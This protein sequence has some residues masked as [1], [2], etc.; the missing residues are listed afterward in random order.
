MAQ[1]KVSWICSTQSKVWQKLSDVGVNQTSANLKLSGLRHQTWH[2]FGGCFNEIGWDVLQSLPVS[3]R[4][5]ILASLFDSSKGCCLNFGR[6]PMGAS[7]Y[8]LQWYS[9]NETEGD[10]AMKHF[11]IDRDRKYL[12][13]YI[14]AA[15]KYQP[16][17]RFF[18]SPWSPPTWMKSPRACNYGT[19]IW[20][21][22]NLDAYALY[23]QK[24]VEAYAKQGIPISQVHVQNEPTADQKF[25]SCL[26]TGVQLRDFIR[27]HLGPRFHQQGLKTEVWLG[28]L[29]SDNYNEYALTV[30][31]DPK[32]RRFIGG[33][34]YQWG[35]KNAIHRTLK[36][37]PEVPLMQTENECGDGKNTWDYAL[38]VSDLVH[39]YAIHGVR[40]YI[41]WNMVLPPGGKSTWGWNQNSMV[42]VDPATGQVTYTPEFYVMKHYSHFIQPGAERLG[43]T[44]QW[45]G[46]AIC[47]ANPDG[48]LIVVVNNPLGEARELGFAH[49]SGIMTAEL[50]AKSVSTFVLRV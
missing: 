29:N 35:G 16:N 10:Y 5:A 44:G 32:A 2:G 7:D 4:E 43:M 36:S 33:V 6:I 39:H 19:L 24:F 50:P 9:C 8:A 25:P 23:F 11:S 45:A 41:Y 15:Q 21:Q 17:I 48:T 1:S 12:I 46:N 30:L 38:Y 34:G 31:S 18:A 20:N 3:K 37:F 26:W 40:A 14:K 22:N 47:F 28:T 13:P 49:A 27:D 42:V